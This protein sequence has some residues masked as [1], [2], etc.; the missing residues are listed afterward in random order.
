MSYE[1]ES[2]WSLDEII[3]YNKAGIIHMHKAFLSFAILVECLTI[4]MMIYTISTNNPGYA[5]FFGIIA[6]LFPFILD[7]VVTIKAKKYYKSAKILHDHKVKLLFYEDS[8]R[9]AE[10]TTTIKYENLYRIIETRT[11]FYLYI[12]NL[13]ALN[14]IKANCNPELIAFLQEKKALVN[15]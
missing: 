15:P 2:F 10:D 12:S 8:F 1:T 7:F 5:A 4:V 11:N 9:T 6:I 14:V 3:K 13:Q